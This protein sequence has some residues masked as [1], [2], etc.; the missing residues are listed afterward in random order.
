MSKIDMKYVFGWFEEYDLTERLEGDCVYEDA[1]DYIKENELIDEVIMWAVEWL[2]DWM[3][4]NFGD[5]YWDA[6]DYA[7]E[8]ATGKSLRGWEEG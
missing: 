8:K 5:N 7:V 3:D 2:R 6:I 4:F 1:L